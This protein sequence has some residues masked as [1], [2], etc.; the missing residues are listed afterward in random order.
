MK[1][2][3]LLITLILFF[4]F[5]VVSQSL[6]SELNSTD[7]RAA[8][9]LSGLEIFKFNFDS[10]KPDYNLIVYIEEISK[11]S[12]ICKE[13]SRIRPWKSELLKKEL[14]II[15][16]TSSDT[17]S[18]YWIN[19][20]HPNMRRTIPFNILP[21]Y[22]ETHIWMPIKQNEIVYDQKIPLLFYGMMWKDSYKGQQIRR[23]CLGGDITRKM[24]NKNLKKV[25]HMLLISYELKK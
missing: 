22:R 17:S 3:A 6:K 4:P 20:L 9:K 19:L 13:T 23:F 15:T 25:E 7:I 5:I 10:V 1:T 24:E 16:K 14:S 11:D 2:K 8:L 12:I 21:K 18:V